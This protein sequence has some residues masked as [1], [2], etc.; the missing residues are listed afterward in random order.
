VSAGTL[1]GSVSRHLGLDL[2]GTN[3]KAVVVGRDGE[4][5]SV[6]D[7]DQVPT[8]AAE[9]PDAVVAR[10]IDVARDL[11]GRA[12]GVTTVGIGIPGLYDP[13]AG[14]TRFLVNIPG[15]WDGRPV[16]GPVGEALG[17]P[18]ALINDARAFGVAELRLGAARGA[19]AMIGFTLGTGVGGVIAVNGRVHQGH[20]GTAGELGHQTIDPDGPWCG[21]GNR[22]CLEA[23][24]RGDQ[25]AA[26]CGTA[27][28]EDA[29]ARARAGDAR[30]IDGFRQAGRYLGIGIANMITVIS[31]DKV[32]LGGGLAV[33]T[34]LMLDAIHD[35]L[36]RRVHTTSLEP[37]EIVSA[38]LG[39]WAGAIGAAIHGA[40]RAEHAEIARAEGAPT[41]PPRTSVVAS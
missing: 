29:I 40:E 7:R 41:T 30:A 20:E 2:G 35:E 22:G 37:V 10:L 36:R 38:E 15:T 27:T 24:A 1:P 5:W 17:L 16:A 34:D 19:S 26:L 31:P 6:L 25:I 32:V 23:F 9:G 39:T 3:V 33:A 21:C 11:V 4:D 28:A 14:T 13:V 12:Q 8:P 18:V